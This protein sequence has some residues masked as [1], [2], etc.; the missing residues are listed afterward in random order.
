M[1]ID[2]LGIQAFLAVA[3]TGGFSQA[4]ARLHL[5]QTAISHRMRKLEDSLGVQLVVRTSR[6]ISLTQAGEALLPRARHA[7]RQL[8]ES[9]DVVRTHGQNAPQW[10]TFGCLPTI[11]AG[12]LAPLLDRVRAAHPQLPVRVFDSSPA[13]IVE[14]VQA[15]TAAFGL[16]IDQ[17][18]ADG[19]SMRLIAREAFVLACPRQHALAA[20]PAVGWAELR[21]Q[22]LIRISLPS[23]NSATID[24]KLGPL[25]EGLQWIYEA[26][27]TAVALKLV[28]AGLGLTIVP[29]LAVQD[30]DGVAVVPLQVP[31][32]S[33]AIVLLTRQGEV[34]GEAERYIADTAVQLIRA[35]PGI[36]PA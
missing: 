24:E 5:S 10:V 3:E 8:E 7:V 29:R 13:E 36:T 34:P 30:E 28:R 26:Q 6:G 18:V 33:R 23:G 12:I 31:E 15:R 35:A 22:P 4:A 14:L 21:G 32:V 20:R 9:C 17:P 27:R 1:Q 16:S 11:A 25:R 19:L 2:F